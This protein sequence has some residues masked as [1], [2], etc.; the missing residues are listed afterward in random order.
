[1]VVTTAD[2]PFCH[3]SRPGDGK[4]IDAKNC[5]QI[6]TMGLKYKFEQSCVEVRFMKV[7]MAHAIVMVAGG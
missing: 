4:E 6:E 7:A 1:M 5:G 2:V 3:V